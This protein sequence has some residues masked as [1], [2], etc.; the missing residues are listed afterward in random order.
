MNGG[1]TVSLIIV[2]SAAG[3]AGLAEPY[4]KTA[5]T[6]DYRCIFNHELLIVCHNKNMNPQSIGSFIAKLE[7]TDV[8]AIMCCPTMW[9]AN[10][11]PSNVDP[12]WRRYSPDQPLSKFRS[13]DY[14]MRYLH[15]GGDPVKDTLEACRKYG[16]DVF[17]SY[18]MNDQH[19]VTDLTWPTHNFIW[20]EHPEYW[21]GDSET[22]PYAR[23]KDNVR[24]LNYMLPQVRD[25][26][27]SII[28]ELCT[29]YDVDGAELDFQRFPRFF[30]NDK[31]AEGTQVMTAFVERLRHMLDR[32]GKERGKSLKLCVRVPETIAKCEKAGLDVCGWDALGLVDMVNVSSSYIH[33]MEL[34]IEQFRERTKRAKIYGEMNYITFQNSKVDKYARRYTTFEVYR[35]SALNLFH[36][37]VDGLSLFNYDY[38]PSKQRLAMAEGLKRITDVE[39]LKTMPKNYVIYPGFGSFTATNERTI[40]LVIPDNV[41]AVKFARAVMRIETQNSCAALRI[42]V[43]LNG[44]QLEPCEHEDAEL[45]PPIAQ[46]AGYA[47]REALKFYTVPLDSLI[48]GNNQVEI[49]NLDK[50]KAACRLFSMELA[51]YRQG[52]AHDREQ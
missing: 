49:K 43:W 15:A 20:R 39:Y 8:D 25:Y 6:V 17:I 36:R 51:L 14:V 42:A 12:D 38:V 19:Y 50:E 52:E 29:N 26:Y 3:A 9:R 1:A 32:I 46:N 23:G 28:E 11:F 5:E 10:V 4:H 7:D 44:T 37:G 33:T 41:T 45:F 30:H 48:P 35:A 18:R 22:S 13:Y 21:L 27:F 24:L 31:I 16:K 34:G 47:A 2:C 40:E